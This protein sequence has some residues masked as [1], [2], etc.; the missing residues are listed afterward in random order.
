MAYVAPHVFTVGEI[1]TSANLNTLG[2]AL[3]ESLHVDDYK[4]ITA[5][6]TG[7]TAT[8]EGTS[9]AIITGNSVTYSGARVFVWFWAPGF[10]NTGGGNTTTIVLYR[11]STVLGQV[12]YVNSGTAEFIPISAF[13]ID[14]PTN[15]AHTYKVQAFVNAGTSII[16]AG[17]GGSGAQ[18]PAFLTV[19]EF[20]A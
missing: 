2:T 12:P 14:T 7:I 16:N 4:S 17:A 3:A 11:D 10:S 13:V 8:T 18:V 1:V 15:A 5:N 6:V 19:V 9:V 20:P